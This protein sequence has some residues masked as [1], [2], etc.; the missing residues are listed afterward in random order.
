MTEYKSVQNS[1]LVWDGSAVDEKQTRKMNTY[2]WYIH[3]VLWFVTPELPSNWGKIIPGG[4]AGEMSA[5]I[6]NTCV[7]LSLAYICFLILLY[8]KNTKKK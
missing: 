2:Y 8:Y 7:S 4:K 1:I 3:V 5:Q 6:Y